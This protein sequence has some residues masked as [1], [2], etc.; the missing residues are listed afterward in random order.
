MPSISIT[1]PDEAVCEFESLFHAYYGRLARF[2]YRVMGD[3]G[4]AEEVASETFWRFYRK[5]PL[6]HDNIEGWLYRTDVRLALDQLKKERRRSRYVVKPF[7][8]QNGIDYPILL[9][10]D[11]IIAL[12]GIKSMPV[13][14]LIDRAGKIAAT[15]IGVV[16]RRSFEQRIRSLLK[17]K[18]LRPL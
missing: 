4:R 16:D 1:A 13:T 12:Y 14:L 7:M 8:R 5:Y 9:G 17:E 18:P 11:H 3:T 2:L 15:H 10:D 6:K